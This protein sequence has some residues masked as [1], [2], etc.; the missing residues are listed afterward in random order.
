MLLPGAEV[1][2]R[3]EPAETSVK[4]TMPVTSARPASAAASTETAVRP[5]IT[6]QLRWAASQ[7]LVFVQAP[8]LR[9]SHLRRALSQHPEVLA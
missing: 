8:P 7:H 3:M 4:A 2:R 9:S 5:M 1:F 6:A